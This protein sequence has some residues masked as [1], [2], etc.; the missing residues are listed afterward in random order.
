MGIRLVFENEWLKIIEEKPKPKTKVFSVWSKCDDSY[1]G[2]V[3]WY[4]KWRHYTFSPTIEYK[5]EY[6]D[7]CQIAIGNFINKVNQEHKGKSA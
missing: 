3:H 1:L 4:P 7:R 6:S 2:E 5:T